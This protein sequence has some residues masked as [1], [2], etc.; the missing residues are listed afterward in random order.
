MADE[1]IEDSAHDDD[2]PM[3]LRAKLVA[4]VT[5]VLILVACAWILLRVSSPPIAPDQ[6]APA[7]HYDLT[8][9][10]CHAVS[11]DAADKTD[12]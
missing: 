11:A 3:S 5:A 8:C 4:G 12:Q 7:G 6:A 9:A 10:W 2:A 1:L